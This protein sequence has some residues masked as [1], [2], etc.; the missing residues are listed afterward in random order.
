M[1]DH[2]EHDSSPWSFR[3]KVAFG[4]FAIIGGFFLVAEHRAHVLPYLPWLF[5]LACPLLHFFHHGHG[6]HGGQRGG[7]Q[8]QDGVSADTPGKRA[9]GTP[10]DGMAKHEGH[11]GA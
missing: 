3:A 8:P 10:G 6:G 4:V 2:L 5:L 9:A 11:G 7:N 1:I